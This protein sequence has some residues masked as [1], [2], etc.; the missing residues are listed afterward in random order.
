MNIMKLSIKWLSEQVKEFVEDEI[1]WRYNN[2]R[3]NFRFFIKGIKRWFSYY[4]ILSSCY[5]YDYSS[6]LE[7]ERAQIIRVRNCISDWHDHEGWER[8]VSEMDLALKLL[9]IVEEDGC[10]ELVGKG[11]ILETTEN[12]YHKYVEDP[13]SYWTIPVYVNTKNF[14]RFRTYSVKEDYED[15]KRGSLAKDRLRVQKAWHLYNRLREQYL[16]TWWT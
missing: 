10:A 11:V 12:G 8:N 13:N 14:K 4:K 3:N 5:D 6:I 7:L 16:K 2:T 15:P 9:D 1:I